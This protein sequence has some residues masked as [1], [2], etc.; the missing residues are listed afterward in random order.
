M[1]VTLTLGSLKGGVGKTSVSV[2]LAAAWSAKA[3]RVLLV[4]ADPQGSASNMFSSDAD[5]PDELPTQS[6][7]DLLGSTN[8]LTTPDVVRQ[9]SVPGLDIIPAV[10]DTLEP[11]ERLDAVKAM[12]SIK[13][14]LA[15]VDDTYDLIV[16]DTPP[17]LSVLTDAAIIASD[18][19]AAVTPPS[20]IDNSGA[21]R[22][23]DRVTEINENWQGAQLIGWVGNRWKLNT[24]EARFI[25]DWARE[26]GWPLLEP[27]LPTTAVVNKAFI[28]AGVP[29]VIAYPNNPFSLA[30][31]ELADN[32]W[33]RVTG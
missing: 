16:I 30:I 27:L 23:A 26:Q 24:A 14:A 21:G 4:D 3:R 1:A 18:W 10:Y 32:I 20:V 12:M 2:N 15:Q 19:A 6:L 25:D 13:K 29:A 22:F 17:R 28:E 9:T 7:G 31:L 33:K 5:D 8:G 11:I